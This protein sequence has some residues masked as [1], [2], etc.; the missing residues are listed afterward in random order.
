MVRSLTVRRIEFTERP[1]R[2]DATRAQGA[3]PN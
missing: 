3:P 2:F 1:V